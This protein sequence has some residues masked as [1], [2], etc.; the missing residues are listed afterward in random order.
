[1]PRS[2]PELPFR[3]RFVSL[4]AALGL[5]GGYLDLIG[6]T[7]KKYFLGTSTSI[8]WSGVH[9]FPWSVP[10]AHALTLM[11]VRHH[12]RHQ[13]DSTGKPITVRFETLW[14]ATIAY[15]SHFFGCQCMVFARCSWPRD[16]HGRSATWIA[17]NR[18]RPRHAWCA[19][20][21][22]GIFIILW[23]AFSAGRGASPPLGCRTS[24]RPRRPRG[25]QCS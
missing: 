20:A 22:R 23:P 24:R 2:A 12:H 7:F 3:H 4:A 18:W 9:D 19:A 25:T 16:W 14:F 21:L 1:M 15:Q 17:T 10:V 11:R 6:I 8:Y 13:C 5:C